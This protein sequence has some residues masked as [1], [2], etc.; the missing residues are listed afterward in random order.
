MQNPICSYDT[1]FKSKAKKKKIKYQIN[2]ISDLK[3]R[4]T[5]HHGYFSL[6]RQDNGDGYIKKKR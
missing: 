2:K 5:F 4:H 3:I 6:V 1:I